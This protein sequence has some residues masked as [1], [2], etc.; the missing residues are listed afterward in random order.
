[1]WGDKMFNL[2]YINLNYNELIDI[3][4]RYLEKKFFQ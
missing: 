1:M 4:K 2:D 3:L